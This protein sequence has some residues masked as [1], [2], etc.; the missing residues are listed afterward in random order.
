[1]Y[2]EYC[3]QIKCY[4]VNQV[5]AYLLPFE[6]CTKGMKNKIKARLDFASIMENN[7]IELLKAIKKRL[8]TKRSEP[9]NAKCRLS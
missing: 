8:I 9:A 6:P 4:V 3:K 1:M 7:T 5:K 2:D